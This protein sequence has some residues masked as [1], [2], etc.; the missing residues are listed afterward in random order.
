M[1]ERE[2]RAFVGSK[3]GVPSP[4]PDDG[5]WNGYEIGDEDDCVLCDDESCVARVIEW[6][7]DGNT[8]AIDLV[9]RLR[10][11]R[12]AVT[13]HEAASAGVLAQRDEA[14]AELADLVVAL[15]LDDRPRRA[16]IEK[17]RSL[18]ARWGIPR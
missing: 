6:Q 7:S 11:A 17:A 8:I 5:E 4:V 1:G 10:H 3:C 18:L 9:E 14:R 16:A 15:F 12:V 13:E 2:V